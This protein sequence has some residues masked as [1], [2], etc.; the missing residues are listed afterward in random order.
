[1]NLQFEQRKSFQ[2]EAAVTE[3]FESPTSLRPGSRHGSKPGSRPG[4]RPNSRPGSRPGSR[5]VSRPFNV[6]LKAAHEKSVFSHFNYC[7]LSSI[8]STQVQCAPE[9][10]N[11]FWQKN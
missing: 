7:I 1:L 11:D 5:P 9:F 6:T 10:H 3:G 8:M 2:F 4:S